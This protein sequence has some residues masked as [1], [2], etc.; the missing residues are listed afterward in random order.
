MLGEKDISIYF[1]PKHFDIDFIKNQVEI[2]E[3][4]KENIQNQAKTENNKNE[5]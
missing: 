5:D 1:F 3:N 2:I 4:N